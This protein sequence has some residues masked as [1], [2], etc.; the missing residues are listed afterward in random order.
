MLKGGDGKGELSHWVE[1][2][3]A[4]VNELLNK[5]GD[6]RPGSP[7]GGQVADLLLG[8][9][10]ASQEQPEQTYIQLIR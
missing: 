4:A 1:V 6:G 9:S 3:G 7:F 5:F 2:R 8:W 10:L